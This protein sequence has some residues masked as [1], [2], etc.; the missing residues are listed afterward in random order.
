MGLIPAQRGI[1][2]M[3]PNCS[4]EPFN[5]QVPGSAILCFQVTGS[6]VPTRGVVVVVVVILLEYS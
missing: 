5:V 3:P 2:E 4:F 6:T 1:K